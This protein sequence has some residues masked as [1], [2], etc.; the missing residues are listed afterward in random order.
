MLE[1][2]VFAEGF[3]GLCAVY[4]KEP[5]K[6]LADIYYKMLSDLSNEQFKMATE[7]ILKTNKYAKI[8]SIAEIRESAFGN[9]EDKA[10]QALA[11]VEDAMRRVGQYNTVVFPDKVIHMVVEALNG[12]ERCCSMDTENEWKWVR[13]EFIALYKVFAANPR[14]YPEKLIGYH[15][16]LNTVNGHFAYIQEPVLIGNEHKAMEVLIHK[17]LK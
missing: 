17:K 4:E 5:S 9:L 10:L 12:W 3:T 15:E 13:K 14:Q 16:R 1:N 6:I 7:N 2:K 11:L 8:P